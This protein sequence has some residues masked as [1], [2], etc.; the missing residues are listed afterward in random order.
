MMAKESP[1]EAMFA[2]QVRAVGLAAGMEREHKFNP[3]RRWRFDFA[4]PGSMIA[5]EIEG[6]HWTGGRHV[7]G[8]GFE[9]DCEKYME[10]V[11]A[12]W[13]VLR[14]TGDLVESGRALNALEAL[15]ERHRPAK[16]GA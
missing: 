11:M 7:R 6:G 8:A 12:G 3:A 4:W 10:A 5:V 16:V 14:V 15:L 13:R 1:L 9:A 2:M